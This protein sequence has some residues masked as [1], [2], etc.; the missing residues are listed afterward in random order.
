MTRGSNELITCT[1]A[2]GTVSWPHIAGDVMNWPHVMEGG[3]VN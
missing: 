2:G 3:L 1:W